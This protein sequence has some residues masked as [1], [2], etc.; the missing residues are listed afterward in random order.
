MYSHL[1]TTQRTWMRPHLF[2]EDCVDSKWVDQLENLFPDG[3]LVEVDNGIYTGSKNA[4]MD[5]EW[6]V[7]NV[8]E[9][10]GSNRNAKGTCLVSVQERFNDTA[11]TT[12]DTFEKAQPAGHMDEEIF[13]LDA[14]T[15]QISAPGERHPVDMSSLP[16]GD[17]LSNHVF[18]QPPA[19]V[20]P[21]QLAYLK[22]L[23]TDIPESLKI[24][25]A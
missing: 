22:E 19:A 9:G 20:D 2:L 11:N 17:T 4:N 1:C 3:C 21:S 7:E 24:G 25:R 6:A 10:D 16:P 23:G 14:M 13:D 5:D 12:Q 15:E 18:M 8:M